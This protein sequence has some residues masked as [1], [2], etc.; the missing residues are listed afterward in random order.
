MEPKLHAPV[1][2]AFARRLQ[3]QS[4]NAV[5]HFDVRER[6]GPLIKQKGRLSGPIFMGCNLLA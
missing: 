4:E 6:F 3:I 1:F 5:K 2:S